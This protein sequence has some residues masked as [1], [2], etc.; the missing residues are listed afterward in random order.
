MVSHGCN[1]SGYS[2]YIRMVTIKNNHCCNTSHGGGYNSV[3]AHC[4]GTGCGATGGFWQGLG[5][6]AL[7]GLTSWLMGGLCSMGS[8]FGGGLNFSGG[9][10]LGNWG[11]GGMTSLW[12][13][14]GNGYSWW[15]NSQTNTKTDDY[16][17]SRYGGKDVKETVTHPPVKP[18]PEGENPEGVNNVETKIGDYTEKLQ[19]NDLTKDKLTTYKTELQALLGDNNLTDEQKNKINNLISDINKKLVE[20]ETQELLAPFTEEERALLEK[21]NEEDLQYKN[22]ANANPEDLKAEGAKVLYA[23]DIVGLASGKIRDVIPSNNN[24]KVTISPDGKTITIQ[25]SKIAGRT[26]EVKYKYVNTVN[27]EALYR[28]ENGQ[29]YVL[30]KI[31][32]GEYVLNQYSWHKGSGEKD[33]SSAE[34]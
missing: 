27:G 23:S 21:I 18:T 13:G 22:Y 24:D 2:D 16:Y 14:S 10:G 25:D 30:Q 15:N 6:G 7:Y 5:A 20:L 34:A 3:W 29:L 17:S 1:C 19:A 9:F 33:V 31:R 26:K 12:G 8:W 4:C 11:L 32:A 28:S